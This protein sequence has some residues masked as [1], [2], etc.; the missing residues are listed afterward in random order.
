MAEVTRI[1]PEE[2]VEKA[3]VF[4]PAGSTGL[5]VYSGVINEEFLTQ[6]SGARG[7]RVFN[8][9]AEND[10]TAGA[11]LAAIELLIRPISWN[12]VAAD[13]SDAAKAEAEFVNTVMRDME[14]PWEDFMSEILTMLPFGWSY[15][16]MIMKRRVGPL[17]RDPARQSKFVDGRIGI[18]RISPRS[19]QSLNKWILGDDNVVE[20]MVQ[21]TPEGGEVEI[22]IERSLHFRTTSRRNN[23]EGRSVL[24]SGYR[25]WYFLKRVQEHE[26]IGIERELAGV[27]IVRVP[28][29]MIT[30]TEPADVAAL[31][32][33][34]KIARDLKFNEQGGLVIPSD[35][36]MDAENR[37][38]PGTYKVDVD[39][40]NTGGR[41]AID[42][43]LTI[44]RYERDIA[45]S[46]LADFIMLGT[47][48]GRGSYALSEDKSNLFLRSCETTTWQIAAELNK[49]MVPRLWALNGLDPALMPSIE[50]GKVAPPNMKELGEF[51]R[52]TTLAG[53]NFSSDTAVSDHLR[54]VGGLPSEESE[55]QTL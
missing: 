25:S 52:N 13:S 51:L 49:R 55:D 20:G 29:G 17:E 26:A 2:P 48:G 37:P 50:P 39:L 31:A 36:W 42:T 33:Y 1:R 53:F 9:M 34:K 47:D 6:L 10:A 43:N 11:I 44:I 32:S 18:R 12:V 30:S 7:M 23:P 41:R 21:W 27:P 46:I 35:P 16:E 38:I 22:P 14:H 40:M 19:Q 8:E 3:G 45:R 4:A 28:A 5:K 15:H 24:R 54:E